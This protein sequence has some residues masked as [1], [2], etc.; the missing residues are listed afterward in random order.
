MP[1]KTST[2]DGRLYQSAIIYFTNSIFNILTLYL[3]YPV[4]VAREQRWVCKHTKIDGKP[5]IFVGRG[6][7]IQ[8]KWLLWWFLVIITI[9]L[10]G[11]FMK[12]RMRGW[13][14][15]NTHIKEY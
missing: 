12:N 2:W 4:T 10:F 5:L 9:S 14:T 3:F 13:I 7:D 15:R 1:Y 8:A 11:F 6:R